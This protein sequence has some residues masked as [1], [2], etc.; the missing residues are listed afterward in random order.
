MPVVVNFDWGN[1]SSYQ[2]GTITQG[3]LTFDVTYF[4]SVYFL[5]CIFLFSAIIKISLGK[6][7]IMLFSPT[8]TEMQE[9]LVKHIGTLYFPVDRIYNVNEV[10]NFL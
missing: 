10:S 1:I 7:Q 9:T 5:I 2:S 3:F 6:W 4:C 8:S